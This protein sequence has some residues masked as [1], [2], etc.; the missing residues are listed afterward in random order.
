MY[1]HV[2]ACCL[3][4]IAIEK[5]GLCSFLDPDA[6]DH[7]TTTTRDSSSILVQWESPACPNGP[8]T[9]YYVYYTIGTQNQTVPISS[10]GYDNLTTS[11]TVVAIT[12]LIA[13]Q[14]YLIHVRAFTDIAGMLLV[15][16]ADKEILQVLNTTIELP[17]AEVLPV[18]SVSTITLQ[19]PNPELFG[20]GEIV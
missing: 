8:I 19:L 7:L 5:S 10:V 14:S 16:E 4:I 11:Q 9:G 18:T 6:V 12:G 20:D 13:T 15:G 3:K 1:G 17:V 2:S